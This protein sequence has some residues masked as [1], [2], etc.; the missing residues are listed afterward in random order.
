MQE[1]RASFSFGVFLV[2]QFLVN[3]TQDKFFIYTALLSIE[4]FFLQRSSSFLL[5]KDNAVHE[6]KHRDMSCSLPF[7]I[8]LP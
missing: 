8:L 3:N 2:L 5:G 6:G 4:I 7:A 1:K